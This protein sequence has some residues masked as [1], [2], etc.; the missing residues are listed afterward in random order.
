LRKEQK[1]VQNKLKLSKLALTPNIYIYVCIYITYIYIY[2][3]R[4]EQ[5]SIQ[6]K[7]NLML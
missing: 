5:E 2:C 4:K 1:S 7:R 3:L 6:N